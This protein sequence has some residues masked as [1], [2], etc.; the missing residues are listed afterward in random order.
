MSSIF[1]SRRI[2]SLSALWGVAAVVAAACGGNTNGSGSSGSGFPGGCSVA[3]QTC[4]VKCDASLGCVDCVKSSDCGVANPACVAGHCQQCASSADCKATGQAC[5]PQNHKCQTACTG[6]PSCAGGNAPICDAT[7][8]ACVGCS[9]AKDCPTNKPICSATTS[10]CV[11]CASN[12][13]CPLAKPVCDLGGG[14]C[15]VCLVDAHCPAATPACIDQHC[16]QNPNAGCAPGLVNCGNGVC[17]DLSA[18]VQHCGQCGQK[19]DTGA[20]ETC[21]SGHC[22]CPPNKPGC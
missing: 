22:V 4:N 15:V 7:T 6:N 10:Q 2:R 20:G 3:G 12:T 5:F 18:D 16:G 11:E 9:T 8:H 13:D 21:S 17:A 1:S 19:C 14:R